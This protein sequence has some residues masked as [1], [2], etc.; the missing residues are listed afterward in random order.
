MQNDKDLIQQLKDQ[1]QQLTEANDRLLDRLAGM[2]LRLDAALNCIAQLR[3]ENQQLKD[4]I[5]RLK[6]QKPRPSIPPSSLEG[7]K[8][9][10][11]AGN[12]IA[13]GKHPRRKKKTLLQIHGKQR[14]RPMHIPEEAVFKGCKKFTVQ[15]I[16]LM[17][18]NTVY[19][20]ERWQL[21]DGTYVSGK[22]PENI[23]GHY[24]PVLVAYILDQ[25]YGCRV[26]EPLLLIHLHEMGVL[27]SAGQLSNILI[28]GKEKF[29]QE[30]GGLLGAGIAATGQIQADDTGARH[31]GQ[32]GY[33]TVI[34][35]EYFTSVTT[36]ESKSRMNFLMILHG[37][38]PVYLVNADTVSYVEAI[39]PENYLRG[40]LQVHRRDATMN[41]E[42]WKQFLF[43]I[44]ITAEDEIKLATEAALF[45]SLIEKGVPRNLG[46]HGDDAGQFNVFVRSLCWIHEERHYR[47]II[48]VDEEARLALEKVREE[49]WDLYRGLKEYKFAPSDMHKAVLD[50]KFE[51]IFL[52]KTTS[53]TLNKQL[54]KT[55]QKKEELLRVLEKP[56]TPLHNNGTETDARE[57]VVVRKISGG[58]RSDDGRKCRDTFVSLKRTCCKLG[59]SFSH[60]LLDRVKRL[61]EIPPLAEVIKTQA[62][63]ARAS[64]LS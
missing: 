28:L 29:H 40:Y 22:V 17:S 27:I 23:H 55:Y 35:N 50:K 10:D 31:K 54:E 58:T 21:P 4:E 57:Q 24:G 19:E 6:G 15:D 43:E 60:Y 46:V 8:S 26:T 44:N 1:V 45:A 13:R 62:A 20:L 12:K 11:K 59:I 14:I 34:G 36:T 38:T 3:E 5:A 53:P 41:T 52:Q 7:P 61:F 49:I 63:K 47:K 2:G 39:K 32:N 16:K 37:S 18:Y 64:P 33:S 9:K 51:T 25:R 42:E 48:P 56:Q 30:K